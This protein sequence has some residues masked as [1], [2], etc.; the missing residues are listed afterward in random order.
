LSFNSGFSEG[1]IR[2]MVHRL[3]HEIRNPLATIKSAAQLI[4]LVDHPEG[5]VAE[6]LESIQTEVSRIDR[7]IR[8]MQRYLRMEAQTA[9]TVDVK[10]SV[11]S[12]VNAVVGS[13]VPEGERIEIKGGP[14]T[15]IVTDPTQLESA[16]AE[17]VKNALRYS[18]PGTPV[19][20][21]WRHEGRGM[22]A[23]E[24]EDRG[25]G[26]P[27]KREDL[28]FRPFF[29]TS[30]HGTGLG[31]NIAGRAAQLAGGKLTWRNLPGGGA[32]F[33]MVLP[34]L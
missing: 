28:I 19:F 20:I 25:P 8:D 16:V 6:C 14:R 7:V 23:I 34:R 17:L 31:L 12:A 11:Q 9:L 3:A 27:E 18:P 2:Q 10:E 33:A 26:I 4:E 13:T 29:S 15:S 30:T 1:D 5:E 24:V 32:C 22:V 21:R